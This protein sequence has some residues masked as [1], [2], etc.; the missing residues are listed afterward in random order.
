MPCATLLRKPAHSGWLQGVVT[1][2][3]LQRPVY[4]PSAEL[5]VVQP[6]EYE[7]N[8]D[9]SAQRDKPIDESRGKAPSINHKQALNTCTSTITVVNIMTNFATT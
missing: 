4:N 5:A 3:G 8:D 2:I 6:A 9:Q 1:G 7:M